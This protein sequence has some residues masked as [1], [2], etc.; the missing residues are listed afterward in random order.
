MKMKVKGRDLDEKMAEGCRRNLGHYKIKGDIKKGDALDF[1]GNVDAIATDPPY[2]QS[3]YTGG[4]NAG[5]LAAA[6]AQ[7]AAGNLKKGGRLVIV[8]PHTTTLK[9]DGLR[10]TGRFD[11][12]VHRSLTRRIRVFIRQK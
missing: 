1:K 12:R 9:P 4:R 11:V 6:F 5:E 2:G 3:S 8:T 10:E 7:K